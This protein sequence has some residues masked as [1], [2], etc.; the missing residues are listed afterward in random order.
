[1]SELAICKVLPRPKGFLIETI[2]REQTGPGTITEEPV[3]NIPTA[4]LSILVDS[5]FV[6]ITLS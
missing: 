1:M 3:R 2:R 4:S 6:Y 5:I